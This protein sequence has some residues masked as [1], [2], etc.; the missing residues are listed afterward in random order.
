MIHIRSAFALFALLFALLTGQARG[1]GL[2]YQLPKDGESIKYD[3]TFAMQ[4][5]EQQVTMTGSMVM[6]AVG[7][8]DVET[9]KEKGKVKARWIEFDFRFTDPT[10]QEQR[11]VVKVLIPEKDLKP[12][13]EIISKR[14][15]GWIRE[16]ADAEV[17]KLDDNDLGPLPAFLSGPLTD[18]KE[19]EPE[20]I[21]TGL[22]EL[23]CKV[24]TGSTSFK[25]NNRDASVVFTNLLHDKAPFG[26]VKS[27][28][29][30][31]STANGV[32]QNRGTITLIAA[33]TG[34]NYKSALPDAK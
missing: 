1:D 22:G 32:N 9:E 19:L 17:E 7:T 31:S 16:R 13:K 30:Y 20:T 34:K 23:K 10:G 15:R 2:F 33:E 6:A 26:V 11:T 29:A 28:M 4:V 12:G 24:V 18:A 8:V 25:E 27:T 21:K 3:M 14:I 5:G